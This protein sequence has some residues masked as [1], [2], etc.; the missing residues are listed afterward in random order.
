[1]TIQHTN[2][3]KQSEPDVTNGLEHVAP[4]VDLTLHSENSRFIQE[5]RQANFDNAEWQKFVNSCKSMIRTS[6]EYKMFVSYC[7]SQLGMTNCSFLGSIEESENVEVEI[8]HAILTL[9]DIVEIVM[10]DML[11]ENDKGISTLEVCNRIMQLH[12]MGLISVVPLSV[13]VHQLVHA[14][15][16]NLSYDQVYG[17]LP[18]FIKTFRKSL[19]DAHIRKIRLFFELSGRKLHE[20]NLLEVQSI[21]DRINTENFTY[22]DLIRIIENSGLQKVD[23]DSMFKDKKLSRSGTRKKKFNKDGGG[24]DI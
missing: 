15:K 4:D 8:H 6:I 24:M 5:Y 13:T 21:E 1:M 20:D 12:F 17:D 19:S 7:K 2:H 23:I 18:T 22:T 11:R 10:D 16:I 3:K 14:K 9:H